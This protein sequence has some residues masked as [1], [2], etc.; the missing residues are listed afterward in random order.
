MML[1]NYMNYIQYHSDR[2]S[3]A[4]MAAALKC[5]CSV[6]SKRCGGMRRHFRDRTTS[7]EPIHFYVDIMDTMHFNVLHLEDV[8]LRVN[9][10]LN[11]ESVE[12]ED[13]LVDDYMFKISRTI[14]SKRDQHFV[15]RLDDTSKNGKFS[16]CSD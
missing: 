13:N 1:E 14:W 12:N 10:D 8:G 2:K 4:K 3:I 6:G 9:L 5:K 15:D 7:L 16:L 11:S